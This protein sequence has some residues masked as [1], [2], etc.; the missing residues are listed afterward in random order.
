MCATAALTI[1]IVSMMAGITLNG[2]VANV[3]ALSPL[4]GALF[5]L[6]VIFQYQGEGAATLFPHLIGLLLVKPTVIKSKCR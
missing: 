5:L 1:T 4:D 3:G 2:G 6:L